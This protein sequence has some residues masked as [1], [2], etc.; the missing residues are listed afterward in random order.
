MTTCCRRT[1]S[2][3]TRGRFWPIAPLPPISAC[4][5][6]RGQRP[7]LWLGR[8][9]A[10]RRAT[11]SD[12]RDDEQPA[13]VSR[14]FYNWYDTRDLRPWTAL[15]LLRGQ[16]QSGGASARPGECLS[17][18]D[19]RSPSRREP[20]AG[21]ADALTLA[22]EPCGSFP[23]TSDPGDHAPSGRRRT[24]CPR[25]RARSGALAPGELAEQLAHSASSCRD[26]GRHRA[27]AGRR[28]QR[29]RG[30][31]HTLLG[32]GGARLDRE[33]APRPRADG[34][35]SRSLKRRLAASS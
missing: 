1:T 31:R 19:R 3:R 28:T 15:R 16:R 9:A 10:D 22:R 8:H 26:P 30:R 13:A 12:A 18:M 27:S 5:C 29:R 2:R 35:G 20:F 11:G 14:S 32:G 23:P 6:C 4:T 24:R 17:G 34:R 25:V 33:L 7:R 21:I